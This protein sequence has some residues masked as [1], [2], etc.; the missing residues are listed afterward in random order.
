MVS[1]RVINLQH[2]PIPYG[3][4]I[5]RVVPSISLGLHPKTFNH[6]T[7]SPIGNSATLNSFSLLA[8]IAYRILVHE[9][10]DVWS[11]SFQPCRIT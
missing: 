10:I 11:E 4:V 3:H 2:L 8:H 6:L 9:S 1:G 5:G 7:R